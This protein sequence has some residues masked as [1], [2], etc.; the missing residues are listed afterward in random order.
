M[1]AHHIPIGSMPQTSGLSPDGK[2]LYAPNRAGFIEGKLLGKEKAPGTGQLAPHCFSAQKIPRNLKV[3]VWRHLIALRHRCLPC[4]HISLL[5]TRA[6]LPDN[7]VAGAP[8][9]MVAFELAGLRPSA[10]NSFL[11]P[12]WLRASCLVGAVGSWLLRPAHLPGLSAV[13]IFHSVVPCCLSSRT[14][15][16]YRQSVLLV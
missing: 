1:V 10:C 5:E 8:M 11:R 16:Q 2:T 6:L 9:D 7:R 14:A 3:N 12:E 4:P 13:C 15:N